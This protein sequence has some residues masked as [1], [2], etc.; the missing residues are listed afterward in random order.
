MFARVGMVLVGAALMAGCGASPE[1]LAAAR[2]DAID[3][4]FTVNSIASDTT[5]SDIWIS[6]TLGSLG[7]PGTIFYKEEAMPV[8]RVLVPSD[9]NEEG[10]TLP[11]DDPRL[12][13]LKKMPPLN[14]QCFGAEVEK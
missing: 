8:L 1:E 12:D 2:Q 6:V 3:R 11:F 14:K 7:C 10:V 4:G 9:A 5:S 13:N